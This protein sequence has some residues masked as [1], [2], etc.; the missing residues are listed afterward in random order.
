M[1]PHQENVC[2]PYPAPSIYSVFESLLQN[3][4]IRKGGLGSVL[5]N[6]YYGKQG[7]KLIPSWTNWR[8]QSLLVELS[9]F[10]I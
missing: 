4:L 2:N 9:L 6:I 10:V 7:N 3:P 8:S 5:P 1:P